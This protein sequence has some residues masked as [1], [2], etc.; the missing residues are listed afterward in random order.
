MTVNSCCMLM[1][2]QGFLICLESHIHWRVD[3]TMKWHIT[4]H[5]ATLSVSGCRFW[6]LII[7][8]TLC[9]VQIIDC[10]VWIKKR[11]FVT[12]VHCS[13]TICCCFTK[14]F[15]LM[16]YRITRW[17]LTNRSRDRRFSTEL[18]DYSW[19]NFAHLVL[20]LLGNHRVD[21]WSWHGIDWES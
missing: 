21:Y 2:S 3:S 18:L 14:H 11:D 9:T 5:Q 16:D 4:W 13:S 7:V 15:I 8:L 6:C 20:E 19:L 12:V 10:A 1:Y 17:T